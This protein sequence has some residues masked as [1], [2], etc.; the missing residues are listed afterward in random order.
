LRTF[1]KGR[2]RSGQLFYDFIFIHATSSLL[3]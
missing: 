2:D 3:T 1:E